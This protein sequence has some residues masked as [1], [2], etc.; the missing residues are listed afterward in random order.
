LQRADDLSLAMIITKK[1]GETDS[2]RCF[3]HR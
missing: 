3:L 2:E 1:P